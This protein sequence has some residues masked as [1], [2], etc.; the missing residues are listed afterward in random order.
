MAL[1][2]QNC[3]L[4]NGEDAQFPVKTPE[5]SDFFLKS[6]LVRYNLHIIK[7]VFLR[8]NSSVCFVKC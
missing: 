1:M 2:T 8:D 5:E 3:T 7:S 4:K 6:G